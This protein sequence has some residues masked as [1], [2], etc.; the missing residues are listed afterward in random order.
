MD[1]LEV[2]VSNIN[3]KSDKQYLMSKLYLNINGVSLIAGS[4]DECSYE[5]L[6]YP[7]KDML[8]HFSDSSFILFEFL[9]LHFYTRIKTGIDIA[10]YTSGI[11][12]R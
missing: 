3:N 9:C 4:G 6:S 8:T 2:K 5:V 7:S 12:C 11:S 10:Y 1:N